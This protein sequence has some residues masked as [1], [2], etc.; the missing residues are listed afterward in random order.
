MFF[1]P[2]FFWKKYIK[3]YWKN[4]GW[5]IASSLCDIILGKEVSFARI[6]S[7]LKEILSDKKYQESIFRKILKDWGYHAYHFS[8]LLYGN[9]KGWTYT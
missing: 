6:K 4:L 7:K 5:S 1:Y 9:Q 8:K 3:I 2:V